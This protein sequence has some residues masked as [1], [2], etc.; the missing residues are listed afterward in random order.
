MVR[1]KLVPLALNSMDD[2]SPNVT[3]LNNPIVMLIMIKQT[4]IYNAYMVCNA[5]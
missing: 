2:G 5:C 4:C 1:V 3:A